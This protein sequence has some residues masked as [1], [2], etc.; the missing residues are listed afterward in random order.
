MLPA[1][2][3]VLICGDIVRESTDGYLDKSEQACVTSYYRHVSEL[4]FP[5]YTSILIAINLSGG[6][7][8]VGGFTLAMLPM[9]VAL[10]VIGWAVYLRKVPKE[11]GFEATESKGWYWKHMGKSLW[12]IVF[13]VVLI[14]TLRVPVYLAVFICIVLNA[15][16]GRFS[17]TEIKPFF[18]SALEAKF[19]VNTVIIMV[20]KEVL[21]ATGV[22]SALPG[23]FAGL[24]I[25]TFLVF[26][27]IFFF[28]SI[29]SGSTAIIVMCM[30]MAMATVSTG[31]LPLF[32]LL[33]RMTYAAM[34]LSPTHVCLA[35]CA[36][37]Y[38]VTLGALI[39]KT[40]PLVRIFSLLA[41]GYYGFLTLLAF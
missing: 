24:P 3:T 10:M 29:V 41:F 8:S 38:G 16:V 4:F 39:R 2:G 23:F 34:Q 9:M 40:I 15:L 21:A 12:T 18:R 27:L 37:D 33:M 17:W 36:E 26:A 1:A 13:T 25:P 14:V 35:I 19:I 22:I 32:V 11:A 30:P 5:T 7:V 6:R 20:F 28:G 31:G